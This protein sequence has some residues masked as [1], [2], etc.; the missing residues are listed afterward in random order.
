LEIFNTIL[1]KY[2]LKAA[3]L[4]FLLK[5]IWE[6]V[7]GSTKKYIKAIDTNTE[8]LIKLNARIDKMSEDLRTAFH[9]IK[10]LRLKTQMGKVTKPE[11]D[12]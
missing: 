7:V 11:R 4:V 9:N 8:A 1:E 2:G 12:Q 3:V 6:V 5:T 10:E